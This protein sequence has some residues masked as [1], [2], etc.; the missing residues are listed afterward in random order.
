MSDSNCLCDLWRFSHRTTLQLV[1]ICA[2]QEFVQNRMRSHNTQKNASLL[3]VR[4]AAIHS[5][6]NRAKI[7][8]VLVRCEL[9]KGLGTFVSF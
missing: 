1:Y 5:Q 3:Q 8:C 6:W 7:S 9:T 4:G 2:L